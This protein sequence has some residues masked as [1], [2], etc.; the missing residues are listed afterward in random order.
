MRIA[1][2][3]LLRRFPALRLTVAPEE[4]PLRLAMTVYGVRELP[5]TW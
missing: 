5:V 2:P 3:A 4:V 1:L